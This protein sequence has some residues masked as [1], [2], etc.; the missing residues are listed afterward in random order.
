MQGLL[1]IVANVGSLQQVE[2]SVFRLPGAEAKFM[3]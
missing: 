3:I 2:Y 1:K